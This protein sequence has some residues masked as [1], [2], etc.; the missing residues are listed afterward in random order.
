M[1][2]DNGELAKHFFITRYRKTRVVP[3]LLRCSISQ[4]EHSVAWI[5]NLCSISAGLRV[6]GYEA[7]FLVESPSHP[8]ATK[9]EP[10]SHSIS[11][12]LDVL[13]NLIGHIYS[14]EETAAKLL[15]SSFLF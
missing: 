15:V 2:A 14:H 4:I 5:R 7:W 12:M 6:Q 13:F 9:E 8:V 11:F 3:I 10:S 1:A